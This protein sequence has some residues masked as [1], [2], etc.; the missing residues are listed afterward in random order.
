MS[1]RLQHILSG[2]PAP[3]P[4]SPLRPLGR[5]GGAGEKWS[6]LDDQ[7]LGAARAELFN[8]DDAKKEAAYAKNVENFIG[9]VKVPIG[10]AGPLRIRDGSFARVRL[11]RMASVL[12][13]WF[14]LDLVA[15]RD[16]SDG[17]SATVAARSYVVMFWE[18]PASLHF[19][20][21][22]L[23][24]FFSREIDSRGEIHEALGI[25]PR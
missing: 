9:T 6:C 2:P 13:V 12:L 1:A 16:G 20:S 21:S 17:E 5:S 19:L 22:V 11:T 10:L 24:L 25:I 7:A 8:A 15:L 3:P 18:G 23:Q 14:S 4:N